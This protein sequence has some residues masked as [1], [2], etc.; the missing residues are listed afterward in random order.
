MSTDRCICGHTDYYHEPA[1]SGDESEGDGYWDYSCKNVDCR[2]PEF[3]WEAELA[4]PA[5]PPR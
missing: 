2:C 5:E 4:E 1:F 3:E